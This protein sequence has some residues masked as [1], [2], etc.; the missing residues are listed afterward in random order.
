MPA[1]PVAVRSKNRRSMVQANLDKKPDPIS[2]TTN[3]KGLE[4][5]CKQ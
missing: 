1:I 3:K 4:A 2:K 5:W